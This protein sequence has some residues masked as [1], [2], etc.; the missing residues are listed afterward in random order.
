Y[1]RLRTDISENFRQRC[2]SEGVAETDEIEHAAASILA[3]MDGLQY[4]WLLEQD[5]VQLGEATR[6]AIHAIVDAI[7][8]PVPSPD[9]DARPAK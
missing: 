9:P 2:A 6:F 3:V 5:V 7:L 4:Q 8:G 1:Q